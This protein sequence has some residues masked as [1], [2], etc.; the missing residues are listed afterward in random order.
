MLTNR[1]DSCKLDLLA[2]VNWECYLKQ[3]MLAFSLKTT[4]NLCHADK[5]DFYYDLVLIPAAFYHCVFVSLQHVISTS[6]F[7]CL[8]NV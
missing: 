8:L 1:A 6:V 3:M 5:C 7:L 4:V 2:E